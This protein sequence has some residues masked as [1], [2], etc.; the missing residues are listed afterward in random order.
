[1]LWILDEPHGGGIHHG[2]IGL[3]IGVGLCHLLVHGIPKN[4]G[5]IKG[6]GLGAV[7]HHSHRWRVTE[8]LSLSGQLKGVPYHPLA[9]LMGKHAGLQGEGVRRTG[10]EEPSYPGVFTLRVL[11]YDHHIDGGGGRGLYRRLHAG[12]EHNRAEV[13]V[14]VEP[15]ANG[16]N[17]GD[18]DVVGDLACIANTSQKDRVKIREGIEHIIG[19]HHAVLEIVVA[20]PVEVLARD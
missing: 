17:Q 15:L 6:V 11:T 16:E 19:H 1:M 7:G 13:N 2:R 12:I 8:L 9:A 5:I 14:L 10:L 18:G 20:S 4:H 3:Y